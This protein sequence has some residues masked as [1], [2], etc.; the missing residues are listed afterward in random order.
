MPCICVL[1]MAA[2]CVIEFLGRLDWGRHNLDTRPARSSLWPFCASKVALV[3][4]GAPPWTGGILGVR[5]ALSWLCW[6]P[7]EMVT[8]SEL[9][10][11][12]VGE[13]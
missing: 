10:S 6:W 1:H 8:A 9:G 7:M 2:V 13:G 12:Q 5:V 3:V 4:S 11:V